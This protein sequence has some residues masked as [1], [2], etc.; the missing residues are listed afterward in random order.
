MNRTR[1]L[2]VS[3]YQDRTH[4]SRWTKGEKGPLSADFTNA[5]D[6]GR[7]IASVAWGSSGP[8]KLSAPSLIGGVIQTTVEATACGWAEIKATVTLDN[9]EKRVQRFAVRVV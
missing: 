9:G 6:T 3:A 2:L 4:E 8:V 7:A 1:Q 5:L